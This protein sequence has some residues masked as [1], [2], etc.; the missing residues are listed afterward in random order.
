MF[1]QRQDVDAAIRQTDNDAAL[2]RVS[3]VRKGY[4]NDPFVKFLVP[5]AHLQP[6]RPPL[7]NIGTFVR[8]TAIDDLVFRWLDIAERLGQKCQIVSLGAGS[9]TRFWK[10]ATGTRKGSL[11]RYI[12]VDFTEVT[13]KKAMAIKKSNDLSTVL[14]VSTLAQ[15]GTALHSPV[16]HLIPGDLRLPPS[17]AVGKSLSSLSSQDGLPL[18]SPSL[19]TLLLFECVLAYISPETSAALLQWFVNYFRG[20]VLGCVVYEMFGLNDP[21]G[22]VMMNNLRERNVTLIGAEPFT[23]L[24]SLKKRFHDV[25]FHFAN[26]ITLKEIRKNFIRHEELERV[27]QLELLDEVE[28]LDLVLDHYAISWGLVPGQDNGWKEWGLEE[29]VR[30]GEDGDD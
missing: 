2:A 28:E 14:G 27:S 25:G 17:E 12:E 20:G 26:A 24:D 1:A 4:L 23:T 6:P 13:T 18:L 22:K 7:I 3:A 29:K 8:S 5:R 9:D 30:R 15:G 21:F 16:Y 10:I 11:A 19:P